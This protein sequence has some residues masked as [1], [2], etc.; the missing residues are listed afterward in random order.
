MFEALK[1]Y[2]MYLFLK[3]NSIFK[4][5]YE[6]TIDVSCVSANFILRMKIDLSAFF[7]IHTGCMFGIFFYFYFIEKR[8]RAPNVDVKGQYFKRIVNS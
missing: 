3:R 1:F 7:R 4:H 5:N 2:C 6:E 8:L